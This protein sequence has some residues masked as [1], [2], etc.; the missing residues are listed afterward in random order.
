MRV[1]TERRLK[2]LEAEL[3]AAEVAKKERTLAVRYHKV[4]FFGEDIPHSLMIS[5]E[6]CN[7]TT[8][9]HSQDQTSPELSRTSRR[10]IPEEEN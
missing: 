6:F 1:E 8:E 9:G 10:E 3:Q 7:R 4:K 2:A 5:A